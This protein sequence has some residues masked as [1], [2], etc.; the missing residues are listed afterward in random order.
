MINLPNEIKEF[1]KYISSPIVILEKKNFLNKEFYNKLREAFPK[2]E[3][4]TK[5]ESN[6]LKAALNNS[7]PTFQK[8][9]SENEPWKF[10]YDYLNSKKTVFLFYNLIKKELDKIEERKKLR[11]FFFTKAEHSENR[12]KLIAKIKRKIVSQFY[13]NIQLSF[14]FSII[15]NNCYIP[16][17]A[18]ATKSILSWMLYFPDESYK[19]IDLEKIHSLG[20][21][22]YKKKD[23]LKDNYIN[24]WEK[25]KLLSGQDLVLF[26]DYYKIFYKTKFEEN[27]FYAFIKN[28]KSW[29]DFSAFN[30]D[31]DFKRKSI[32][33]N[34]NLV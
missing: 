16:P 29:H 15:S 33:I 26:K 5:K 28:D 27:T 21:N 7:C 24:G 4:M 23:E 34:I 6:G 22:F 32:N 17:H 9:I 2:E 10:F 20:T 31:K 18:D 19:N 13:Q 30:F 12:N 14:E 3:L 11:K 8:V 25:D 1:D